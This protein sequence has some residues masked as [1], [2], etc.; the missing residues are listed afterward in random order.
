MCVSSKQSN[1]QPRPKQKARQPTSASCRAEV[2]SIFFPFLFEEI[3]TKNPGGPNSFLLIKRESI[4]CHVTPHFKTTDS[5]GCCTVETEMRELPYHDSRF[6]I[7]KDLR[8]AGISNDIT[9]KSVN[10]L[11]N[12]IAGTIDSASPQNAIVLVLACHTKPP[13]HV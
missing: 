9:P 13:T 6:T 4:S 3:E 2:P 5:T 8:T 11:Q 12:V 7:H 1:T 10:S